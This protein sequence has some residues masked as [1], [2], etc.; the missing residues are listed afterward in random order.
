MRK[1]MTSLIVPQKAKSLNHCSMD[2]NKPIRKLLCF[3]KGS[4]SVKEQW[5]SVRCFLTTDKLPLETRQVALDS[6]V[7]LTSKP[8][9]KTSFAPYSTDNRS[10]SVVLLI[11]QR[12]AF[13]NL[14]FSCFPFLYFIYLFIYFFLHCFY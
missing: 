5:R 6:K 14:N 3:P 12:T 11:F 8:R 10:S 7:F 13:H 1:V 4:L 9:R 2:R